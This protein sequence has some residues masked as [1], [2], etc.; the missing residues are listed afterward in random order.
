MVQA[1]ANG[2]DGL[3]FKNGFGQDLSKPLSVHLVVNGYLTVFRAGEGKGREEEK[4]HRISP[5]CHWLR[6]RLCPESETFSTSGERSFR[7]SGERSETFSTSGERRGERSTTSRAKYKY[8]TGEYTYISDRCRVKPRYS[9]IYNIHFHEIH[10]TLPNLYNSLV[11]WWVF[12]PGSNLKGL[13]RYI[14]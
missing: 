5:C 13:Y 1:L 8:I 14:L 7:T 2:A 4:R 3:G 12:L 6:D 10:S 9:S 11:A